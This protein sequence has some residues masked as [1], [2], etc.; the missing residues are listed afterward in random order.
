MR[1]EKAVTK[2]LRGLL[3][4]VSA[5]AAR[6]PD[7]AAQLDR[8]LEPLPERRPHIRVAATKKPGSLPDVYAEWNARGD[9]EFRLW[10]SQQPL[11]VLRALIRRH[12]FDAT[13]RTAKWKEP[14]KL[15]DYIADHLQS[16]RSRGSSFM[17]SGE[18]A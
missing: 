13:R 18:S 8:L 17:R 15:S 11:D 7:F 4:L 5:E 6:N 2:L 14:E 12:D 9:S 16:R 1:K 3:D 10:L